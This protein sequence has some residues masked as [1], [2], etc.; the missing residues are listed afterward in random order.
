MTQ[1]TAGSSVV[2]EVIFNAPVKN[3]DDTDFVVTTLNGGITGATVNF[4]TT[5]APFTTYSVLVNGYNGEGEIR[6]DLIDDNSID[7]RVTNLPLGGPG[8][9]NGSFN[10]GETYI[11]DVNPPTV[12]IKQNPSQ[13]DSTNAPPIIF[14]V[15]F[16]EPV[17]NFE[18]GDIALSGS[19]GA[20]SAVVSGSGAN[21]TVT[22]SGMTQSGTVVVNIP[23]NVAQD[24]SGKQNTASTTGATINDDNVVNYFIGGIVLAVDDDRMASA[25][26]RTD[27]TPTYSTIQS[28]V[29]AA[30]ANYTI[31]VCSGTYPLASTV[32]ASFA[33]LTIIGAQAMK[34][35]IQVSGSM[36]AFNVTAD[37]VTVEKLEIEKIGTGDQ[38]FMFLLQANNFTGRNNYIH[39]PSWQGPPNHVSK[40]FVFNA[41]VT[42]LLL[43]GN[44]IENLRQPAYFNPGQHWNGQQ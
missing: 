43:D 18:T 11:V 37:G 26:S 36:D 35:L 8:A 41:G 25:T 31:K 32:N 44:T 16:S 2:F 19:A 28:A 3:V 30:S 1:Y 9:G 5:A 27:T 39:G 6:L 20:N 29:A 24:L 40:G 22:V 14:D 10:T 13:P 21:Y 23:A 34:P 7:T 38:H 12:T 15:V 42:G 17:Q 4:P 33:N